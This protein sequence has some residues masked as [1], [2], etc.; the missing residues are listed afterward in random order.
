MLLGSKA[1]SFLSGE[2]MLEN[3][4]PS[5]GDVVVL[6]TLWVGTLLVGSLAAIKASNGTFASI[7]MFAS[8][9][10]IKFLDMMRS[11]EGP[12]VFGAVY[13]ALYARFVSQWTYMANLYNQIKEVEVSLSSAQN[14]SAGQSNPM[15]QWK[16]GFI[17]DAVL[18][19]MATKPA[20]KGIIRVWYAE[21]DVSKALEDHTTD[22]PKHEAWLKKHNV[23]T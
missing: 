12:V 20:M 5:G 1:V 9:T 13:A 23:L 14:F 22:W 8:A 16:A 2:W 21:K 19:H 11:T 4:R 18:L 10:W 7:C 17:E 15:A 6:R 3:G